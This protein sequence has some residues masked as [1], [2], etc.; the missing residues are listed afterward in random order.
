MS[1]NSLFHKLFMLCFLLGT[2]WAQ[3]DTGTP[4]YEAMMP[5]SRYESVNLANL[6][7][8]LHAPIRSKGGPIPLNFG[9]RTTWASSKRGLLGYPL[10]LYDYAHS[11][12]FGRLQGGTL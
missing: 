11:I 7:I 5:I 12:L 8:L 3:S 10:Q 9:Y 2:A 1:V 6:M 4:S